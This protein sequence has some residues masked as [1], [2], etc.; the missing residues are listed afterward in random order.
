[1]LEEAARKVC[2]RE[3][4]SGPIE[5]LHGY[6]W[7]VLRSVGISRLRRGPAALS[8][9]TLASEEGEEA[10]RTIPS[11][12]GSPADVERRILFR[13][14]L[15]MLSPEERLVCA[16]K[17]A[18]LSSREIARRR[19]TTTAAIDKLLSRARERVRSNL[20]HR[21]SG[22]VEV[23]TTRVLDDRQRRRAPCRGRGTSRTRSRMAG[24]G[25]QPRHARRRGHL[26]TERSRHRRSG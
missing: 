26:G 2:H 22:D 6:A 11:R 25:S 1:V 24:F 8:Q 13:Q 23:S 19:G 17:R 21:S 10:M 4:K 12:L 20:G 5:R 3:Q 14:V 9:R 16:W 18:G 7:V 15:G